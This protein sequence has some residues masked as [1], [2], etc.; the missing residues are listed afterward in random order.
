[1]SPIEPA[2]TAFALPMALIHAACFPTGERWSADAITLQ[3]GVPGAF[4]FVAPA[5]GFI[6]ARAAADESEI[7]TLA[8]DPAARR[9]GLGRRLV[10]RTLAEAAARGAQL[11]FLE[12]S[13]QNEAARALYEAC[14]FVE[15]GRRRHYYRGQID[16]LVL[17]VSTPCGSTTA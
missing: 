8:V 11:T 1:M 5:G 15:F 13:E 9:T 4:G 10:G 7:L 3:L 16:A 12:V 6:L 2:T 14:G 17:R